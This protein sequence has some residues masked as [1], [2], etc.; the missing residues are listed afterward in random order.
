MMRKRFSD[1]VLLCDMDGTLLN[2]KGQLSEENRK[3]IYYFVD[4][5]GRFTVATG[6][7]VFAVRNYLPALPVN[8]P[9]I[10]Y[11]GAAIY[12]FQKNE[13]LWEDCLREDV[14]SVLKELMTTFPEIGVEVFQGGDI[15]FL[16]EHEET[17]K[18]RLREGFIPKTGGIEDIPGDWYKVILACE[19]EKLFRVED[20]LRERQ[21]SFRAVY[22]EPQFLELLN[23]GASKGRAMQEL[24]ART[25]FSLSA[26]IAMG[27][28]MNDMEMIRMAG[29]G[30]APANAREEIRMAAKYCCCH[31][32][33]HAVAEIIHLLDSQGE[34]S[35]YAFFDEGKRPVI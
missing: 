13:V 19:P 5:G 11:N 32:D 7:M 3:A 18:H 29:L 20:F 22:S 16:R 4:N 30:V 6:R 8:L 34:N 33:E 9:A 17:E 24:A 35:F 23:Q 26:V 10:L 1:M 21:G 31:H 28:H 2:S 12:D 14:K 25:G 15:Y 27:D